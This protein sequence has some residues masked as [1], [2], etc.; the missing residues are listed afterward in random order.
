L[1]PEI[2]SCHFALLV[3]CR[4]NIKNPSF[5]PHSYLKQN[6]FF[7]SKE[8]DREEIFSLILRRGKHVYKRGAAIL[9]EISKRKCPLENRPTLLYFAYQ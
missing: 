5:P 3:C 4:P 6:S 8:R 1:E 7:L 9:R 2:P